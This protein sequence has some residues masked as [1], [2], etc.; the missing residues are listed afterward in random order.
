MVLAPDLV[1]RLRRESRDQHGMIG[2]NMLQPG[3]RA[4]GSGEHLGKIAQHVPANLVTAI[5]RRLTHPQQPGAFEILD[6]LLGNA[7]LILA[8]LRALLEHRHQRARARHQLVGRRMPSER[9]D[10]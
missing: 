2:E 8:T 6:G 1:L 9:H 4:V 7:A 3:L 10:V 5:A